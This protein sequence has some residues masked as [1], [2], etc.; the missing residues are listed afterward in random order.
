[1]SFVRYLKEHIVWAICGLFL[2]VTM[3]IFLMTLRGSVY[4]MMYM[5]AATLICYTVGIVCDF[6]KRKR[7]FDDIY[8][9]LDSLDKKYLVS[10]LVDEDGDQE[11]AL[12]LH[13]LKDAGMSMCDHVASYRRETEDYKDYIE[14]WIHEVKTP[15]AAS[16]MI[17]ENHREE[18]VKNS[19]IA[20]EIDRIEG[21]VEQALF[22]SRSAEVEKD[23]FIRAFPVLDAV[24]DAVTRRKRSFISSGASVEISEDVRAIVRSDCKWITFIIGQILDNSLKYAR[25]DIPLKIHIYTTLQDEHTCLHIQDNGIGMKSSEIGRAFDKGFT[26]T[27]GRT[28]RSST[29][30]GLYLCRKL[31]LRLGHDI[32]LGSDENTGTTVTIVF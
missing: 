21:Y 4:L 6:R 13:I 12:T 10:E 5:T 17:L 25:P 26:G 22:Y 3:D 15:I 7:D 20:A 30:I 9:K 16:R 32:S 23:Y 18:P 2:I 27:N 29:G 19:G 31:C 11:R 28:G 1:M 24:R 8:E 14:T